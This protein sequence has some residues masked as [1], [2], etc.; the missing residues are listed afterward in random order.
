MNGYTPAAFIDAFLCFY[1]IEKTLDFG[2]RRND[3]V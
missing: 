3:G 1:P 2:F